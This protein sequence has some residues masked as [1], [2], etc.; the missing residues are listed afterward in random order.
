MSPVIHTL[1]VHLLARGDFE[2][3]GRI[4]GGKVPYHGVGR[5]M[6]VTFKVS[7]PISAYDGWARECGTWKIMSLFSE[8]QNG[9]SKGWPL[10]F[11]FM[12][13]VWI[14]GPRLA[15][16]KK[17]LRHAA[18]PKPDPSGPLNIGP[19]LPFRVHGTAKVPNKEI[20]ASATLAMSLRPYFFKY[21]RL[22]H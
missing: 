20:Q 22:N 1:E 15:L 13:A 12:V 16:T 2:G 18:P 17:L 5:Y 3:R 21:S 8:L 4:L 11:S 7:A 6:F 10:G 19:C 9:P 14:T